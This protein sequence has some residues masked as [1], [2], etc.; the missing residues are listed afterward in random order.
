MLKTTGG[1]MAPWLYITSRHWSLVS[2]ITPK[3][4]ASGIIA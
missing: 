3:Y 4:L 1:A 2:S